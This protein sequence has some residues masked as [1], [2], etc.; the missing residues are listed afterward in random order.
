M[1]PCDVSNGPGH[2]ITLFCY[3]VCNNVKAYI[4]YS[5]LT[6]L[7]S[8]AGQ[9][10]SCKMVKSLNWPTTVQVHQTHSFGYLFLWNFSVHEH[11]FFYV[12][13]KLYAHAVSTWPSTSLVDQTTPFPSTA[14]WCNTSSAGKGVV[15]STRLAFYSPPGGGLRTRLA[16]PLWKVQVGVLDHP[17]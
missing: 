8:L 6:E 9:I 10:I 11:T 2:Y 13:D 14:R 3:W 5:C 4:I 1:K 16:L 17:K 12:Y 7:H 15:W